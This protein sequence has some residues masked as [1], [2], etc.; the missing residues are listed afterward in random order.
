[1]RYVVETDKLRHNVAVLKKE[2]PDTTLLAVLKCNGYGLG[3]VET[4]KLLKAE[5]ITDFAVLTFD[6]AAA[7]RAVAPDDFVMLLT[8]AVTDDE[9]A[10]AV[11]MKLAAC[12]DCAA[13]AA[14]L[15]KAAAAADVTT[16]IQLALDMGF[17][18]YGF[19]AGEEEAIAQTL[20]ACPHLQ[21]VGTYAHF[22]SSFGDGSSVKTQLAAFL[23]MTDKLTVLGVNVGRRHIA[24]SAA[25]LRFADTRLD[26]VRVGS[27]LCG[28]LAVANRWGLQPVGFLEANITA[29][30]HLKKGANLGYGDMYHL[31]KDATIAVVPVGHDNGYGVTSMRDSFRLRDIAR[32]MWN[33]VKDLW[34]DHRV[35]VTVN[36]KRA[37]LAAGRGLT[38]CFVDVT[39]IPCEVGDTV[40]FSVSSVG[41]PADVKREYR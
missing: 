28:R 26:M 32:Y 11:S 36:G 4:A 8:P 12:V 6:E 18:R 35:F 3:L 7:L 30:K 31:K 33:N 24:N 27:A 9:A 41:I 39:D 14:R 34:R 21:V 20:A 22:H 13:S 2:M 25:A 5:G 37:P 29:I 10:Q 38:N 23:T 1:M 40:T 19:V 17:G 15:E 16:P